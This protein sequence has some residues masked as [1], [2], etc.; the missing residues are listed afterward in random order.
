MGAYSN[1]QQI[2]TRVELSTRA[3]DNFQKTISSSFASVANQYALNRE[4]A[5]KQLAIDRKKEKTFYKNTYENI[6]TGI[7]SIVEENKIL[8][9][10]KD[11]DGDDVFQ[12]NALEDNLLIV[13]ENMEAEVR[14][15]G[16]QDASLRD[17][18]KIRAK[19]TAQVVTLKKDLATFVEGYRLYQEAKKADIDPADPNY[20]MTTFRPEVISIYEA[21]DKGDGSVGIFP[22]KDGSFIVSEYKD[23]D[24][25]TPKAVA[26]VNLTEYR[27]EI[28]Q[29]LQDKKGYFDF[30]KTDSLDQRKDYLNKGFEIFK[31]GEN[32]FGELRKRKVLTQSGLPAMEYDPNVSTS[33]MSVKN[34]GN[35]TILNT[36]VF[37]EAMETDQGKA[38]LNGYYKAAGVTP[39]QLW[40]ANGFD[41]ADYTLEKVDDL[42]IENFINLYKLEDPTVVVAQ[43]N[44][45]SVSAVTPPVNYVTATT[46][47]NPNTGFTNPLLN[48][49]FTGTPTPVT[50]I[51]GTPK[52]P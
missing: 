38:Y 21:Y 9:K 7:N 11:L 43:N 36:P 33:A 35:V 15:A 19:Y 18:N 47:G 1:P 16:G 42:L 17:I 22:G 27:R 49:S 10:L 37:R 41:E 31:G 13:R 48:T 20:L 30:S 12:K 5:N 8:S 44:T 3:L 29:R 39:Q 40:V 45:P 6:D 2:Q 50:Q 46:T 24:T 4:R 34:G 32:D 52:T 23:L 25:D 28:A 51:P 14:Q 26:P